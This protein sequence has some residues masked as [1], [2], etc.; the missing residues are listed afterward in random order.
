MVFE[1]GSL[2]F[3]TKSP[4]KRDLSS[5][6][7]IEVQESLTWPW[8]PLELFP[9]R[10]LT[11]TEPTRETYMYAL[12]FLVVALYNFEPNFF[13]WKAAPRSRKSNT[14]RAEATQLAFAVWRSW[15]FVH[16]SGESTVKP[17]TRP[18][19]ILEEHI[20]IGT[21]QRLVRD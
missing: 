7:Q 1:A 12:S 8:K 19:T 20:H 15:N 4:F 9:F 6:E 3:R 13:F 14:A 10:R 2:G 16:T 21:A 18:R 11:F 17:S 5:K